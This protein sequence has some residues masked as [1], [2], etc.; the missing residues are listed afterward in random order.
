MQT[1]LDVHML[2]HVCVMCAIPGMCCMGMLRMGMLHL[3]LGRQWLHQPRKGKARQHRSL[4]P[5]E[6]N[7]SAGHWGTR[8][9][10]AR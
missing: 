4:Q 5:N 2:I 9:S 10:S 6:H 8:G 1:Q 3:G 7:E